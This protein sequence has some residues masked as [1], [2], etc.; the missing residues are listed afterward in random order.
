MQSFGINASVIGHVN[1]GILIDSGSSVHLFRDESAFTSWDNNF[2]PNSVKIIL[3]DGTICS[4][5]KGKGTVEIEVTDDTGNPHV[6][7]LRT[8]YE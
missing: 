3:A 1:G 5:I 2:D 7:K 4:D 8:E 6:I